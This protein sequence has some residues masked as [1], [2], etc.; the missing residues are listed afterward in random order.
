MAV[1]V[2]AV[3]QLQERAIGERGRHVAQLRETMQAELADAR[4]IALAQRRPDDDVGEKRE[5][6]VGKAAEHGGTHRQRVRSDVGVE[7]RAD[8]GQLF[9][10]L[11][12]RAAAAPLVEHVGGQRRQT[13]VSGRIRRRAAPD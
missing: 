13:V 5:R 10:N 4:E 8:A 12:R 2:R 7:L 11:N 9:V 6:A 1:R 3:Q